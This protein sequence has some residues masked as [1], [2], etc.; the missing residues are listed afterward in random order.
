M[1]RFD[2]IAKKYPR[3]DAFLDAAMPKRKDGPLTEAEAA[4]VEKFRAKTGI[5][6]ADEHRL[7]EMAAAAGIVDAV[8]LV[9]EL[10]K[11]DPTIGRNELGEAFGKGTYV[12][13]VCKWF[14]ANP[15]VLED[16]SGIREELALYD[17][18]KGK[19][20]AEFRNPMAMKSPTDV[21]AA[22][23]PFREGLEAGVAITE[24]EKERE[25]RRNVM[26]STKI[27]YEGPEGR[28]V[29]PQSIEAA[30][31]W[32]RGTRWCTAAEN[33]SMYNHYSKQGP[34]VVVEIAGGEKRQFHAPSR[35]LMDKADRGVPV[36]QLL[37][38]APFVLR[39]KEASV[40]LLRLD[41]L[42]VA[43][44]IRLEE[45][46]RR[47]EKRPEEIFSGAALREAKVGDKTLAALLMM[48]AHGRIAVAAP[49]RDLAILSVDEGRNPDLFAGLPA[50]SV[51]T[52]VL[53]AY[54]E[55]RT[56]DE[57]P[58]LVV[59]LDALGRLDDT[60]VADPSS[61]V[62]RSALSDADTGGWNWGRLDEM[63]GQRY[64]DVAKQVERRLIGNLDRLMSRVPD[65][66][67]KPA[68]MATLLAI[69]PE[70]VRDWVEANASRFARSPQTVLSRAV[71]D[72]AIT[73][74]PGTA[75]RLI[76]PSSGKP[77]IENPTEELCTRAIREAPGGA[78]A[79][80]VLSRI[81][82]GSLSDGT[83]EAASK[84]LYDPSDFQAFFDVA[85]ASKTLGEGGAFHASAMQHGARMIEQRVVRAGDASKESFLRLVEGHPEIVRSEEGL[86]AL[87]SASSA[88]LVSI[89]IDQASSSAEGRAV[90]SE[91]LVVPLK[92]DL[93]RSLATEEAVA[94]LAR[95][96]PDGLPN[97]LPILLTGV[98]PSIVGKL[99]AADI[100]DEVISESFAA[101]THY[102]ATTAFAASLFEA[103]AKGTASAEAW[104]PIGDLAKFSS[105]P[106][107]P[108]GETATL[109]ITSSWM[110]AVRLNPH[111]L[112]YPDFVG[113][114]AAVD[115]ERA[116]PFLREMTAEGR[117]G[118]KKALDAIIDKA[119]LIN[120]SSLVTLEPDPSAL[121]ASTI[122]GI[123]RGMQTMGELMALA[124]RVSNDVL[125]QS[126]NFSA[127]AVRFA[128]NYGGSVR[129]LADVGGAEDVA[130]IA[131]LV[132]GE[133]ASRAYLSI[134]AK[135]APERV[136]SAMVDRWASDIRPRNQKRHDPNDFKEQVSLLGAL[137]KIGLVSET[138]LA[139]IARNRPDLWPI[140]SSHPD[141]ATF[142]G[143][144]RETFVAET[145]RCTKDK[146]EFVFPA[147]GA[148]FG[149]FSAEHIGRLEA[150]RGK[151]GY[152]DR[153]SAFV[154]IEDPKIL[155][156]VLSSTKSV[157]WL[158]SAVAGARTKENI[159][160]ALRLDPANVL[161]RLAEDEI[162]ED[163]IVEVSK[164]CPDAFHHYKLKE[165]MNWTQEVADRAFQANA[166]VISSIPSTFRKEEMFAACTDP[167][168]RS[169]TWSSPQTRN[170][171]HGTLHVVSAAEVLLPNVPKPILDK[172]V[173]ESVRA[174]PTCVGKA[175][176]SVRCV[177]RWGESKDPAVLARCEG[178]ARIA[179]ASASDHSIGSSGWAPPTP[180]R[181]VEKEGVSYLVDDK[182][183][184]GRDFVAQ[185]IASSFGGRAAELASPKLRLELLRVGVETIKPRDFAEI[186]ASTEGPGFI[187]NLRGA[188]R[189][190]HDAFSR[191]LHPER[192]GQVAENGH[193]Q[194]VYGNY[195]R[196]KKWRDETPEETAAALRGA[197]KTVAGHLCAEA[198]DIVAKRPRKGFPAWPESAKEELAAARDAVRRKDAG[199]EQVA[200]AVET[201]KR[202]HPRSADLF[203]NKALVE[204]SK[205]AAEHGKASVMP[206]PP[207]L[208]VA[209]AAQ[210]RGSIAA[211]RVA[212]DHGMEPARPAGPEIG[213]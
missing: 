93:M 59:A 82:V 57:G 193:W 108:K 208:V 92:S 8:G 71:V 86:L 85:R 124:E 81:P 28:V 102:Q 115:H 149:G 160:L 16:L 21:Y 47:V 152:E 61:G 137:G 140:V 150:I 166:G 77:L 144:A 184:R 117:N 26:A 19:L 187:R 201:L 188:K 126:K 179:L 114:A 156:E 167:S 211:C 58:S 105:R 13:A 106:D 128:Y 110:D 159:D 155:H 49:D 185:E 101:T 4:A 198:A 48:D 111:L 60:T 142:L 17:R 95:S 89:S 107:L 135:G 74:R 69:D 20:P 139:A 65:A 41:A 136:S 170:R 12:E 120:P 209:D 183:K 210:S 127:A 197:A 113:L 55:A 109:A 18:V 54:A 165:K 194:M 6:P 112:A 182:T 56:Y 14:S 130:R 125:V 62:F 171:H 91:A 121:S 119:V 22:I 138:V 104:R 79:V 195:A 51:S 202:F 164:A 25:V 157:V 37:N 87:L 133:P 45:N 66:M 64:V 203:S 196:T 134:L 148:C 143:E 53:R 96:Y 204:L 46:R 40:E 63:L 15:R 27:L 174:N 189:E 163:R 129:E 146:A 177:D 131:G 178:L 3:L 212:L 5:A 190:A 10:S 70:R 72:M 122:D 83:I 33:N 145:E 50:G 76:W 29:I 191:L 213:R 103:A 151:L 23:A 123:A 132:R 147:D 186:A 162:T 31:W 173:E 141:A 32:G 192:V 11:G 206:E 181:Y 34:L 169:E 100:C 35:Q 73:A 199:M 154:R 1:N 39:S 99:P 84:R 172:I 24:G 200:T 116:G 90:L 180:S 68:V 38:E 94:A 9:G 52:D 43:D 7:G 205:M 42:S 80:R 118:G 98:C 175:I 78:S 36:A 97:G 176:S 2:A 161:H 67:D 168:A 88:T 153:M 207:R 44:W 75:E 158:D 30:K